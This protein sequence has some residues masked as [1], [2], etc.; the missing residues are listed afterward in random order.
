MAILGKP[1]RSSCSW[2]VL[3]FAIHLLQDFTKRFFIRFDSATLGYPA[4]WC[5]PDCFFRLLNSGI[6]RA[7]GSS[8][9]RISAV[10]ETQHTTVV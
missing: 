5:V 8:A 3:L 7:T 1:S 6:F 4:S 10:S 2:S 9:E